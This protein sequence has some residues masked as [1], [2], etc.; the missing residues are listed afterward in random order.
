MPQ[1]GCLTQV[2]RWLA[3][4]IGEASA[5]RHTCRIKQ[6]TPK[7]KESGFVLLAAVMP[8]AATNGVANAQSAETGFEMPPRDIFCIIEPPADSHSVSEMERLF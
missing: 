4:T 3:K 7:L 1:P 5:I 2:E 8:P 6:M